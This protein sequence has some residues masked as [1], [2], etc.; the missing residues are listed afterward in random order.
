MQFCAGRREREH[1]FSTAMLHM[2]ISALQQLPHTDVHLLEK[3]EKTILVHRDGKE[4]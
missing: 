4:E 3:L 2:L 1:Q